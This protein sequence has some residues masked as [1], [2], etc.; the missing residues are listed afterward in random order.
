MHVSLRSD[1]QG[2]IVRHIHNEHT[3]HEEYIV[4]FEMSREEYREGKH[5]IDPRNRHLVH[6]I[7]IIIPTASYGNDR[8]SQPANR[9][10][11]MIVTAC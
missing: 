11:Q 5:A 2:C 10:T 9:Y 6:V 8:L 4:A 7:R 1:F 3:S